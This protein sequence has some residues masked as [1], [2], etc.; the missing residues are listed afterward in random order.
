MNRAQK[1]NILFIVA[2]DLGWGDVSWHGSAI[3]TPNLDRLAKTGLELDQHYVCPVCTPTRAS[4][5]TGRFAGRFGRH[6]TTPSNAPVLPDGYETLAST[7]SNG[8]YDTALF[9]KWHLGSRPEYGPHHFGFDTAY[10]SLAGGVDPYNHRYKKGK[11]SVTWHRNG[12]F[13]E[14]RGHTSD[15]L[16]QAAIKWIGERKNPWFCYMP[17]TAVHFPVKAPEK[18]I[19]QYA[20]ESFDEDPEKDRSYRNYAAYASHM[21]DCIGRL[22]ETLNEL[23]IRDHT[24]IIFTSDNGATPGVP[25]TSTA[26]YPGYQPPSP[27]LGS[28]LP[29]RGIKGQLYEGAIR[30]PTFVNWA[31][32]IDPGKMSRPLQIADW[33]PT[34]CGIT[35]CATASDPKWDGWDIGPL[36][37]SSSDDPLPDLEDRPIYWNLRGNQFAIRQAQWK[38]IVREKEGMIPL[39]LYDMVS[40]PCETNDLSQEQ[41]DVVDQLK[42]LLKN[43][44][45]HDYS[46]ARPEVTDP[47][48]D[49]PE[50]EP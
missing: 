27:K 32:R 11:Y 39:E 4:L 40:D 44:R 10:G 7:L 37:E 24:L 1:P 19:N 17:F 48:V 12:E 13:I 22:V 6:A 16:T 23:C 14:E 50:T 30:T 28:N 45:R 43:E 49:N 46:D 3:R 8:G 47:D 38:L 29:W 21:D 31:G 9:G 20:K 36:L 18:W 41:P 33:M 42:L 26:K 25:P 34:L 35:D 5:L 2:D 15:L